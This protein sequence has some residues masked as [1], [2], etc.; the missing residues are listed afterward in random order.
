MSQKRILVVDDEEGIRLVMRLVLA[1]AD[2]LVTEVSSGEAALRELAG[3]GPGYDLVLL[4]QNMP[5]MSGLETLRRVRQQAPA[6]K[7]IMLSGGM[8]DE[9]WDEVSARTVRFLPK[10]FQNHELL[11]MVQD[12]LGE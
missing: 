11:Q 12:A 9:L 1:K 6:T 7:V 5:E 2:F 10:P 8:G 3:P 4:D